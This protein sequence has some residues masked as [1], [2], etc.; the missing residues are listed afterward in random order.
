MPKV[1]IINP[2]APKTEE[3]IVPRLRVCAYCRVSS[4]HDEQQESFSA[5]VAHYTELIT[6]NDAWMFAGIYADEGISGTSKDKRD[7]FM[8]LMRDCKAKKVDMVITKSISRFARNT[9]DCIEAVRRLKNLGIAIFFEK[10]NINTLKVDSELL[11]T[12]LGSAAQEESIAISSNSR[13]SIQEKFQSGEWNPSCLPYGYTKDDEGEIVIDEAEAAVVRR[14][15]RD[16]LNGKGCYVIARELTLEGIPTRKGAEAWGEK[17]VT[18]ILAN[19]KYEGDMLMQKTFT[20]DTLPFTRKRNKGQKQKYFI[21]N[22]H[23][24]IIAREEARRVKEIMDRRRQEKEMDVNPGK[25]NNRY[26]FTGKVICGE[27]GTTFK[28]QKIFIGKPYQTEQWCCS[29][30]IRKRTECSMTAIKEE[31]IKAAF[32]HLYNKL[33]S[34]CDPILIPLLEDLKKL[35][36]SQVYESQIK[37]LNNRIAELTE[38][39]HV[40]SRLRSK[41]YLDS[42]LFIEQNNLVVKELAELKEQRSALMDYTD[43]DENIAKTQELI[44][45]LEQQEDLMEGFDENLFSLIVERI[46]VKSKVGL[47]F[48]LINGLELAELIGEEAS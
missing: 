24:P 34:N 26:P 18:E 38:Q 35:H 8:R 37:K 46:T 13:W 41:G 42:V 5:Q 32:T 3:K 43:F 1:T 20:T 2:V 48:R 47:A 15:Y 40:F 9:S 30:H 14:T 39:S 44:T 11:I 21:Q 7:D 22:N 6:A 31:Y 33:K 25:Y 17:V 10:E 28:R 27:C 4:D 19:E 36:F 23:L 45:L 16:Y 29:K 12:I